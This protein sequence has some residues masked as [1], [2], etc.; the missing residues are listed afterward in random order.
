MGMLAILSTVGEGRVFG[1]SSSV[2]KT[3]SVGIIP[4]EGGPSGPD[5][6]SILVLSL[7]TLNEG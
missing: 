5:A 1:P 3:R 7:I 6:Q 4:A 2:L